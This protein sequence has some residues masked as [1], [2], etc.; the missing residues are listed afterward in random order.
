MLLFQTELEY[1]DKDGDLIKATSDPELT[2]A[3]LKED[4]SVFKAICGAKAVEILC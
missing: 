2:M 1:E 3:I 4:L